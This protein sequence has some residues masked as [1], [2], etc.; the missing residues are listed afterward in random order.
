LFPS[1]SLGSIPELIV[2][3]GPTCTLNPPSAMAIDPTMKLRFVVK[4]LW[5]KDLW[6]VKRFV[7]RFVVMWSN[8]R[9]WNFAQSGKPAATLLKLQPHRQ[10][11]KAFSP[12]TPAV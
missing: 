9:D 3:V 4:D 12:C 8:R 6:S 11:M 7:V 2:T 10:I 1:P 5:S